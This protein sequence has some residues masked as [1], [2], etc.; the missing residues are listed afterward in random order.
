MVGVWLFENPNEVMKNLAN[1]KV[2]FHGI[3]ILN[4]NCKP[5]PKSPLRLAQSIGHLRG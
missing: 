2:S 5:N 3:T 1:L 4:L